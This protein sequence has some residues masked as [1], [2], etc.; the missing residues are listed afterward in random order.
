METIL[1]HTTHRTK[2]SLQ[3]SV[4]SAKINK[5]ARFVICSS[6]QE[7][8]GAGDKSVTACNLP[9]ISWTWCDSCTAVTT[10]AAS[11]LYLLNNSWPTIMTLVTL[12]VNVK[13]EK[14]S[15]KPPEPETSITGHIHLHMTP[16]LPAGVCPLSSSPVST[17]TTD[18]AND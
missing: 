11:I 16:V 8:V 13:S 4:K 2:D 5:D 7:K 9:T 17:A 3:P 15:P 10:A 12:Y 18:A 1:A 14:F 6:D